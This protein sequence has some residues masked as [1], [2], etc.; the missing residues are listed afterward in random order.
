M[1]ITVIK[2]EKAK[3]HNGNPIYKVT[4]S[5]GRVGESYAKEIPVNTDANDITIEEGTYG[6]KFKLNKKNGF[7]G[8]VPKAKAGNESFACSYSKDVFVALVSKMDKAPKSEDAVKVILSMAEA[9]YNWLESKKST[10]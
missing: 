6:L 1:S 3:E 8:G 10:K 7:G 5:D 9:F 4:L 2:C